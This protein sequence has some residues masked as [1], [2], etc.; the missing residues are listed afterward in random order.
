MKNSLA[1]ACEK[2]LLRAAHALEHHPRQVTALIAALMLGGGGAAFGVASIDPAPD[3]VVVRQVIEDVLPLPVD[4]QLQALEQ[5][6]LALYRSDTTR[7]A[8]TVD[9]LLAR[10]GVDEGA[11][12]AYLRREPTFRAQFLARSGRTVSV[13]TNERH[14][15]QQLIGLW[16]PDNSA[17]FKRLVINRSP[18]GLFMSHLETGVL[19][20]SVRLGSASIRTSLFAAADDAHMPDAVVSQLVEIF[21]NEI[22]FHHDLRMGDRFNVVYETLEAD[23][24]PVRTGRILSAEFTNAGTRHDAMWFQPLGHKGGYYSLAGKSLETSYLSTPLQFSRVSSGFAMRLHPILHQWKAHLGVDFAASIGTPVRTVGEGT[25]E[26]AGVQNGFGNVVIVK[27]NNLE[28]TVYAH[29]SRI[30]VRTGQGVAQGQPIGAV[31]ESGWATG[32]HLHFEFRVNGVHQDP[33]LMARRNEQTTLSAE[34]RP[35]FDRAALSMRLQLA[36]AARETM[37]AIK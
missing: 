23:G 20:P 1:A 32:P 5:H 21:S 11:A 3:N 35:E 4:A 7:P 27:H 8:E 10:V 19:T 34:L 33:S 37:L 26:F 6:G 31:G 9:A 24:E 36:A 16:V 2:L 22:D 28:Q 15:L 29:L 30:A 12:A 13:R 18:D 17:L 25:V 14:E